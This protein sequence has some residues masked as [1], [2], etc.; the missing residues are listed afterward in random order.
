MA[1]EQ[2]VPGTDDRHHRK[3]EDFTS[4]LYNIMD[5]TGQHRG[6]S[7]HTG[8]FTIQ[9]RYYYTQKYDI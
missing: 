5:T 4:A 2:R 6:L 3:A 1:D 8:M 9:I 7:D